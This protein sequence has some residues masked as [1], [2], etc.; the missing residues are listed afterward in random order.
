IHYA[1]AGIRPLP[2]KEEGPE[3]AI[4]RRHIIKENTD[5][6]TGLVSIVGGKL[7]TYRSLAEQT[8]DKLEKVL[9]KRLPACRT[10][11]TELPGAWGLE[12]ARA[13]LES[14]DLLSADGVERMLSIYGGR[15][16]AIADLCASEAKLARALDEDRAVLA[17]EVVFAIRAEFAQTLE[18]IVFRRL[19]IGFNADQGRALYEDIAALA[20][21]ESGWSP[22]TVAQ[23]L[24]QL[25]EYAA[26]LRVG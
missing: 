3:S 6:A 13:A 24:R 18:D 16:S 7:T 25:A 15:A 5:V 2:H 9:R 19:M 22:E 21:A 14:L 8:V 12:R 23:Q 1:Y 11:E 26:S 10:R 20:A 4:T 17:A